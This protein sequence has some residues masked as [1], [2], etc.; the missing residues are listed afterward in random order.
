MAST[1]AEKKTVE[2]KPKTAS[3]VSVSVVEPRELKTPEVTEDEKKLALQILQDFKYTGFDPLAFRKK[4][5]DDGWTP[6]DIHVAICAYVQIGNNTAK[7]KT[8]GRK[9][10]DR[11]EEVAKKLSGEVTLAR[12]AIAF[13]GLVHDYRSIALS[14]GLIQPRFLDIKAPA[15]LQDPAL[16]CFMNREAGQEFNKKFSEIVGA[17]DKKKKKGADNTDWWQIAWLGAT[18]E[19]RTGLDGK[20]KSKG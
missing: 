5:Y 2:R 6:S 9:K 4:L 17:A 8:G 15:L 1:D 19:M 14:A 11:F 12:L 18:D 10:N 16:L 7:A 3:G 20:V 13:C